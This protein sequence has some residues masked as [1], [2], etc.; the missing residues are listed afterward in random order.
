[1]PDAVSGSRVIGWPLRYAAGRDSRER[2]C[3]KR[4]PH[5]LLSQPIELCFDRLGFLLLIGQLVTGL[6]DQMGG[7]FFHVRLVGRP[8]FQDLDIFL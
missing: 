4:F 7:R 1:M 5:Q 3:E 2:G 6:L 8:C